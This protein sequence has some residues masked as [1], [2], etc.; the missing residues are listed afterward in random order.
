VIICVLLVQMIVCNTKKS[1]YNHR[2]K[3][4]ALL[5]NFDSLVIV[6][7]GEIV[8]NMYNSS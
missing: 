6:V 8:I 1:L 5:I 3:V 7:G 4:D 2:K